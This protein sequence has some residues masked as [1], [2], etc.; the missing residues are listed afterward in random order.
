MSEDGI[1]VIS[2]MLNPERK[3]LLSTPSVVSKGL[4]ISESLEIVIDKLETITQDIV[5]AYLKRR[6]YD[7]SLLKRE[8]Q[9][10]IGK[11]LYRLTKKNPIIMS[12]IVEVAS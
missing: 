8:L 4:I 1:V 5:E 11:E 6:Y 2:I 12:A 3:K 10:Q 7:A 9:E